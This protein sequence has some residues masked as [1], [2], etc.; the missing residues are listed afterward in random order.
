MK[1]TTAAHLYEA[2][3]DIP[4]DHKGQRPC[5]PPC[6]L[7]RANRVHELPDTTEAQ[8][9]HLRRIGDDQ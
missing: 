7:P 9:A 3:R 4:P 2:D 8:A 6:G 5:R 1:K